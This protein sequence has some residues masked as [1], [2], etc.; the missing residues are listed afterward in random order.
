MFARIV[1]ALV[2]LSFTPEANAQTS[3]LTD[4]DDPPYI[5]IPIT[6]GRPRRPSRP[7]RPLN[8]GVK[9]EP[10]LEYTSGSIDAATERV[11]ATPWEGTKSIRCLRVDRDGELRLVRGV[12]LRLA[13]VAMPRP[14]R[15]SGGDGRIGLLAV[16]AVK[17]LVRNA[18]VVVDLATGTDPANEVWAGYVHT[19]SGLF[20]NEH[21]LYWG[22]ASHVQ[23][24]T[25]EVH[26]EVLHLAERDA[27]QHRRGLWGLKP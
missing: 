9:R 21:L 27:R 4:E 20:L 3:S 12:R 18:T 11:A 10:G 24:A 15:L 5:E 13:E 7:S 26:S 17:G 14:S 19:A 25:P 2:L 1:P 6:P 8:P 23:P 22:W 16:D